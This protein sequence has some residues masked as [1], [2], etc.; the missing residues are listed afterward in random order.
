[1][2]SSDATPFPIK[3]QA[4]RVT[5]PI[6]DADGDL[7]TGA[8]GLDSEI[9][10]DGG[11]FADVT[12]E[13]TEIATAS[14]MYYLD[15]TST[16]MNA[17]TV[18]LIIKTTTTEAKT[19]P[20]VLYPAESTDIPVNVKAI[21]DDTSAADNLELDY[22]GTGYTKANS[23]IGTCT[24]NTD[25]RGT[26]NAALASGVD[27]TSIHGAAL[28]ETVN[29]YLAAAFV[30]LF[31][32]TT[33]LLV[34]SDAM[35]GTDSAA[36]AATALSDVT[37]TDANAGYLDASIAGLNNVST[38]DVLAQTQAALQGYKLDHLISA[39][40]DTDL[41]TTVHDNSVLGYLMA[42]SAMSGYA[43][44]T[45]AV[46]SIRDT[47][48]LGTAMRGTDGANTTTPPT[49]TQIRQEMDT[50]STKMAPSQV[51]NDYKATGFNTVVPDA[52]GTAA[53]LHA[54]TDGLITTVDTV[55]DG[56]QTDLS[57]ATDGLGALK[58]LIDANQT[59]LTNIESKVDTV[60][61]VVDAILVDTGTTIDAMITRILGISQENFYMDT[62]V[63]TGANMTSCR[64]RLYSVAGSVGTASDVIATYNMTATYAG[65]NLASYKM[66]KT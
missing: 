20:I 55:A 28:T 40:V 33:P 51:L 7:V 61:G 23:T 18:A 13:A 12:A 22:D 9:S 14:G 42:T 16:E 29:G 56:I 8:A 5:F 26:D 38:A 19:T 60:D 41:P 3:N 48:P 49:V 32:V 30:K 64:I 1:M 57:N 6:L 24:T 27:L 21:S 36:L 35:R 46:Q 37:W 52:A 50:N 39:A 10:K 17:D 31:D 58:T 15:L 44:A 25:M 66:V 54:T 62:T 53:G 11:T 43:R 65:D 4:Y 59:D 63:F 2:A 47:A 45:D 34:A